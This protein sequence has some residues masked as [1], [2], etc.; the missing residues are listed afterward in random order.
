MLDT[1][2]QQGPANHFHVLL[3]QVPLESSMSQDVLPSAPADR[4]NTEGVG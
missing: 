2:Y 1:V 3:I 4:K